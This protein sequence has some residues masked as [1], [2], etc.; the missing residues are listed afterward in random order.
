MALARRA[1]SA[2]AAALLAV[3]VVLLRRAADG[4]RFVDAPGDW[5]LLTAG[6]ALAGGL[7]LPR[8]LAPRARNWLWPIVGGVMLAALTMLL[9]LAPDAIWR[10]ATGRAS[11]AGTALALAA[12]GLYAALTAGPVCV[13]GALLLHAG[14]RAR[15]R[16]G[17]ARGG[18]AQR[19][20][21]G[22]R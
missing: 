18:S 8:Y 20:L 5:A 4:P 6:A 9:I 21:R 11:A 12:A 15:F 22:R 3:I 10:V 2:A 19:G 17:G 7:L 13:A 16:G 1:I 14:F